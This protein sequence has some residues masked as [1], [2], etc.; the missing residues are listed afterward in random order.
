MGGM[1]VFG[2]LLAAGLLPA[3][4]DQLEDFKNNSKNYSS[5]WSSKR[6]NQG[7]EAEKTY[8][9]QLNQLERK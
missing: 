7:K 6:K 9:G 4:G 1:L 3:Y 2:L 8:I 5:R